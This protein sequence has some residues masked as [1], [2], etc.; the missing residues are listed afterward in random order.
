MMD[1]VKTAPGPLG[2]LLQEFVTRVAHRGGR[3]L[4]V[5][6]EASVTLQQ[7]ILLNRIRETPDGTSSEL[8]AALGMSLTSVSQMIDRLFR[9]KLVTR[10]EMATDRR[11]KRIDLTKKGHTL[12]A[13]LREARSMEFNIS[14]AALSPKVQADLSQVLARALAELDHRVDDLGADRAIRGRAN[15]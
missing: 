10:A 1:A 12:L 11:K 9:L 15:G 2:D 7:V 6:N 13:R 8:A 3:T 5:M 14:A 4:T